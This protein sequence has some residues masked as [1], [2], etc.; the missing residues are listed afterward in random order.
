MKANRNGPFARFW[1]ED[2]F[3]K[4]ANDPGDDT[5]QEWLHGEESLLD[6]EI[7]KLG[8]PAL[9]DIG[10]G[11]GR[12]ISRIRLL[13]SSIVGIDNNRA[14]LDRA[15]ATKEKDNWENVQFLLRDARKTRLSADEFDMT[16]CMTNTL[17]NIPKRKV[18]ALKEMKRVTRPGGVIL[19]S[20]YSERA[21]EARHASYA[22][23]KLHIKSVTHSGTILT[24]EGLRSEQF[25]RD[26][27]A[28]LLTAAEIGDAEIRVLSSISYAVVARV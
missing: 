10:C 6:V 13:C 1:T 21:L 2:Y 7:R 27:L 8:R 22:H 19:L 14:V 25:T 9:L 24:T 17:G 28:R 3:T 26:R 20:V 11:Y 18:E 4:W 15:I 23:V 12:H 16:I 5:I